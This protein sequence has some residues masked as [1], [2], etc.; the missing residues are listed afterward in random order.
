MLLLLTL[1]LSYFWP[2][3]WEISFR[4]EEEKK[5]SKTEDEES[6]FNVPTN[7]FLRFHLWFL[8][9]ESEIFREEKIHRILKLIKEME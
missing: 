8:E 4:I 6:V 2:F 7:A 5:I 9:G 1:I 3:K